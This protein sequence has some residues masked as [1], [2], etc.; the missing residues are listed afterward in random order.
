MQPSVLSLKTLLNKTL[1]FSRPEIGLKIIP[2][3]RVFF[4]IKNVP[5]FFPKLVCEGPQDFDKGP[6]SCSEAQHAFT[7]SLVK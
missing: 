2:T 6:K 3:P 1:V 5:R 7:R 4:V